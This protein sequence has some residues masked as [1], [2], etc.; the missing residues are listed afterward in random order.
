MSRSDEFRAA[1]VKA[2]PEMGPSELL[3]LDEVCR[4]VDRLDNFDAL[5]TGER[6][7]WCSIDW[8]YEDSPAV[9]VVSSVLSEARAHVAELR[10]VL[11]ALDI[12]VPKAA[13]GPTRLEVLLGGASG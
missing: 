1:A 2:K 7:A 12:P 11:K 10:Q 6:E 4:L 3:L 5:L 13:A 8:P 9:V